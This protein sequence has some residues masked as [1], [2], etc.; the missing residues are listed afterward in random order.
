MC[1]RARKPVRTSPRTGNRDDRRSPDTEQAHGAQRGRIRGTHAV[2][3]PYAPDSR[4]AT[5]SGQHVE[6]DPP[7]E[8]QRGTL[9]MAAFAPEREFGGELRVL[10]SVLNVVDGGSR[11]TG[12][13]RREGTVWTLD[14]VRHPSVVVD[15]GPNGERAM[16]SIQNRHRHR[17]FSGRGR[18]GRALSPLR[19]TRRDETLVQPLH[20]TA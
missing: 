19:S 11:I 13:P 1:A 16:I 5:R 2:R 4:D 10:G 8:A 7:S 14:G 3:I 9:L 18:E 15:A 20:F 17:G 12:R 6:M